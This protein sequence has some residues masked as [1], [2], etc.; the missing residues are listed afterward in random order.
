MTVQIKR[1]HFL[2]C[3]ATS[4]VGLALGGLT[5]SRFQKPLQAAPS[6]VKH[7]PIDPVRV[8]FVGIGGRGSSLIRL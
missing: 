5:V 3:G 8:G 1:R 4:G 2:K 6:E 7:A